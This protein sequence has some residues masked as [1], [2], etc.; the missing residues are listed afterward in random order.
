MWGLWWGG[1]VIDSSLGASPTPTAQTFNPLHP[2]PFLFL[3]PPQVQVILP[4]ARASAF[5]QQT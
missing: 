5:S 2:L 3:A 1:K 4:L